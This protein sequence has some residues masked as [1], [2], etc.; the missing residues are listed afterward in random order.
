MTL[1][2]FASYEL[3]EC[4]RAENDEFYICYS[5][6]IKGW[7][8]G[9]VYHHDCGNEALDD[10]QDVIVGS[11]VVVMVVPDNDPAH[12]AVPLDYIAHSGFVRPYEV[13]GIDVINH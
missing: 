5:A 9:R 1:R 7:K 8:E 6:G 12:I 10:F 4:Q 2:L 3:V 13:V 11:E